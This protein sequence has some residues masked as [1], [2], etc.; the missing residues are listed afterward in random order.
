[1][2]FQFGILNYCKNQMLN[3]TSKAK[4]LDSVYKNLIDKKYYLFANKPVSIH[5]KYQNFISG[6]RLAYTKS[7]SALEAYNYNNILEKGFALIKNED[8]QSI[9]RSKSIIKDTKATIYFFDGTIKAILKKN[10]E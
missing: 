4:L 9:T 5:E 8:N 6:M 10:G 3:L 7:S 2:H 1:M